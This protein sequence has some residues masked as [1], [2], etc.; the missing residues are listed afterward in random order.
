MREIYRESEHICVHCGCVLGGM[1]ANINM[2]IKQK[3]KR[4]RCSKVFTGVSYH[5]PCHPLYQ[6]TCGS[7]IFGS[8]FAPPP[9]IVPPCYSSSPLLLCNQFYPSLAPVY[10]LFCILAAGQASQPCSPPCFIFTPGPSL[11]PR[12]APAQRKRQSSGEPQMGQTTPPLLLNALFLCYSLFTN[13]RAQSR[14]L[15]MRQRYDGGIS[16]SASALSSLWY[17]ETS[18]LCLGMGVCVCV[19]VY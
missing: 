8:A 13:Q 7:A 9:T 12:C 14:D 18:V 5:V 19:C 2:V 15:P 6:Q 10:T 3:K 1:Y 4:K 16:Q 17:F 11:S